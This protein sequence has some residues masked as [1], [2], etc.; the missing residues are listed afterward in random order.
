MTSTPETILVTG[1]VAAAPEYGEHAIVVLLNGPTGSRK[2]QAGETVTVTAGLVAPCY[3]IFPDDSPVLV[4]SIR[5]GK[6]RVMNEDGEW[7]D[8]PVENLRPAV[9]GWTW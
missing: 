9:P 7:W 8:E 4:V 5:D 6:A 2:F 1:P 3:A